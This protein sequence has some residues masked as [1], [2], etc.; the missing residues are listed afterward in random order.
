MG[1]IY[2]WPPS[3]SSGTTLTEYATFADFPLSAPNGSLALALDTD[4][5]YVFNTGSMTWVPIGA[6]IA[7]QYAVDLFTLSPGDIAAKFV[8]LSSAPTAATKTIL[9]VVGGPMQSYGAD[10]IVNMGDHLDW[11]GLF[12]DGI[13]VSGD[14]FIVQ[15]I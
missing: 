3:G 11:S 6:P 14:M 12:L 2:T 4:I 13:L 1:I 10:F 5:L 15:F 9:T 7:I 8:T